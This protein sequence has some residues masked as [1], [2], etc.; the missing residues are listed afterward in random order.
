MLNELDVIV[1][2]YYLTLYIAADVVV[3]EYNAWFKC[4]RLA[5][6]KWT[7][8]QIYQIQH[9]NNGNRRPLKAPPANPR[10]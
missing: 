5:S 9:K 6:M 1:S 7:P 8:G 10:T 3:A 4:L 2:L